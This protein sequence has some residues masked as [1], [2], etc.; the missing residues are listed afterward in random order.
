MLEGFAFSLKSR[1]Y[2]FNDFR[3][4]RLKKYLS[5]FMPMPIGCKKRN[6]DLLLKLLSTTNDTRTRTILALKPKKFC[7]GCNFFE[8]KMSFCIFDR[9]FVVF[10][11]NFDFGS[12][13]ENL[14][15]SCAAYLI[16]HTHTRNLFFDLFDVR[17]WKKH[18]WIYSCGDIVRHHYYSSILLH[19]CSMDL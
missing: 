15:L 17:R 5:I 2:L 18:D 13:Q 19:R 10:L 16:G 4:A 9:L 7:N 11:I 6:E 3:V 1:F 14:L 8:L 12:M